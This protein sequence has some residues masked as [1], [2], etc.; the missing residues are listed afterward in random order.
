MEF[1]HLRTTQLGPEYNSGPNGFLPI[2]CRLPSS[3]FFK[4]SSIPWPAASQQS[5]PAHG[6]VAPV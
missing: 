2:R 5:S 4:Q 1:L 6:P 3:Y